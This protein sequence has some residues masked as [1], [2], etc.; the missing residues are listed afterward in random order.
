[1]KKEDSKQSVK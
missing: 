1:M